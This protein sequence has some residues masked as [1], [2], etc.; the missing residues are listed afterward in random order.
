MFLC[1]NGVFFD[2]LHTKVEKIKF[3]M[4]LFLIYWLNSVKNTYRFAIKQIGM[5]K[6]DLSREFYP[7]FTYQIVF[8]HFGMY[9]LDCHVASLLAMTGEICAKKLKIKTCNPEF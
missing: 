9:I 3:G 7:N 1:F 4:Y 2:Y 5:H 6:G 8:T